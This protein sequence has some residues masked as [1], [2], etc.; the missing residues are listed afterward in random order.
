MKNMHGFTLIELMVTVSVAAILLAVAVPSLTSVYER[1]RSSTAINNIENSIAF[2]RNQAISYGRKIVVC[3]GSGSSCTG[4]WI[5]GYVIF[6]DDDNDNKVDNNTSVL[7]K[8]QHLNLKDFIKVSPDK[9]IIFNTDGMLS[10]DSE[11]SI[12]YCP[13]SKDSEYSKGISISLS[14]KIS[15]ITTNVNCAPN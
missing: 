6:I 14:G 7:K 9:A 15:T 8:E 12:H 10:G 4:D 11:M 5:D 2:A 13:S 1:T 3:P